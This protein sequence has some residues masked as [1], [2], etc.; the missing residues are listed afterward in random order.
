MWGCFR[1]AIFYEIIGIVFPTHVGV[2]P[3]DEALEKMT[4]CLPHACGGVS[5]VWARSPPTWSSSPRMWGCFRRIKQ[6]QSEISVFPTHVGVFLSTP[7]PGRTPPCLPHACGGV[8]SVAVDIRRDRVSSPRMWGCFF[9]P[10]MDRTGKAVFPTH[11]GV[12]LRFDSEKREESCLPHACGGVSDEQKEDGCDLVSSPRMW[13]CF[14]HQPANP[15]KEFVFPT[16]V[17]VFL[18]RGRPGRC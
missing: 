16:H 4:K 6:I 17:G 10:G 7:L 8:S 14:R 3:M 11:V 9:F 1:T 15:W 12:F 2:F 5:M 18:W 13:G